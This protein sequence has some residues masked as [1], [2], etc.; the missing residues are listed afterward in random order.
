MSHNG[1]DLITTNYVAGARFGGEYLLSVPDFAAILPPIWQPRSTLARD[2]K[3]RFPKVAASQI[4]RPRFFRFD[5]PTTSFSAAFWESAVP[6]NKYNNNI[7]CSPRYLRHN[8][9]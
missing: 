9:F 4:L 2:A 6:L 7:C 8:L 3:G 1:A 5:E